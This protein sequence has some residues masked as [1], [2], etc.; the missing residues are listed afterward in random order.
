MY[1]VLL[2]L[3]DDYK[4]VSKAQ[5]EIYEPERYLQVSDWAEIMMVEVRISD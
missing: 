5:P 4:E 3:L 2:K 1:T